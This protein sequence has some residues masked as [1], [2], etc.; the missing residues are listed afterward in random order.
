MSDMQQVA[1]AFRVLGQI[2]RINGRRKLRAECEI[3]MHLRNPEPFNKARTAPM[4]RRA[5][6]RARILE[7]RDEARRLDKSLKKK[8]VRDQFF[9][10]PVIGYVGGNMA[11]IGYVGGNMEKV[12]ASGL[13]N[14]DVVN[15]MKFSWLHRNDKKPLKGPVRHGMAEPVLQEVQ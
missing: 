12:V 14:K 2:V 11:V 8:D 5:A 3:L 7:L 9:F 15:A 1:E 13:S 6:R 4:P 10:R